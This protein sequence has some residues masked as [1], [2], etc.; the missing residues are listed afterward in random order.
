MS[1][2]LVVLLIAAGGLV[3]AGMG[4]GYLHWAGLQQDL[5]RMNDAMEQAREQQA[6]LLHRFESATAELQSHEARL[7]E[8]EERLTRRRDEVAAAQEQLAAQAMEAETEG[9]TAAERLIELAELRL[10]VEGDAPSALEALRAADRL[11]ADT[12]DPPWR[13]LSESLVRSIQA[14]EAAPPADVEALGARLSG[15]RVQAETLPILA[16]V[17][18]WRGRLPGA[19]APLFGRDPRQVWADPGALRGTRRLSRRDLAEVRRVLRERIDAAG[20]ALRQGDVERYR[21]AL[22]DAQGWARRFLDAG[23]PAATAFLAEIEDLAD[24]PIRIGL[25][26]L[27]SVLDLVR[28]ARERD[29]GGKSQ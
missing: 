25:P 19:E 7:R 15:L 27:R 22:G 10:R 13:D 28:A 12:G 6:R 4:L 21:R 23:D 1:R 3:L 5:A 9:L 17:P 26:D 11:L 8:Q 20:I 2:A 24:T 29:R 18:A 14:L 16:R